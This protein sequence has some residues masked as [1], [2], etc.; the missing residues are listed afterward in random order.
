V[1]GDGRVDVAGVDPAGALWWGRNTSTGS[2]SALAAKAQLPPALAG[3]R[4]VL[5]ADL[6]GDGRKDVVGRAGDT[7]RTWRNTG[8]TTFAAATDLG[9]GWGALDR[10][11]AYDADGDDRTDV[12]G[13]DVAGTLWWGRNTGTGTTPAVAAKAQLGG[14]WGGVRDLQV[15]D[16]D[17]DRRADLVGRTGDT[18]KLWRGTGSA[19]Q[20]AVASPV[21]LSTGWGPIG[22]RFVQAGPVVHASHVDGVS[23]FYNYDSQGTR[24]W[25]FTNVATAATPNVTWYSGPNN[26]EWTRAKTVSG[27]FDGDGR[28]DALGLYNYDNSR[29]KLWGFFTITGGAVTGSLL[30]DSGAGNW[31]WN[32]TKLLAGDFNGDG[33]DDLAAL[34]RYD[35]FRTG[36]WLMENVASGNASWRMAWDSGAG[37]WDLNRTKAV[38]GDVNGDGK[39]DIAALYGY[40]GQRTAVW[41]MDAVTSGGAWRIAYDS[42][43]GIWDWNRTKV[44]AGDFTGD[45]RDD[46]D[47][48]YAYDGGRTR[49]FVMDGVAGAGSWRQVWD[50]GVNNWDGNRAVPVA[51]DFDGDGRDDVG[52]I[53]DYGNAQLKLWLNTDA[54]A[55]G[56]AR[57]VWDS[58]PGNWEARRADWIRS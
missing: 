56:A 2:T 54:G 41:V 3:V 47:A 28:P 4:D 15:L 57:I 33:K 42:G 26:W 6:D 29:S 34:Y 35:G 52:N 43:P 27:D 1:D 58:G 11:T 44:V 37:N 14:G 53:Y 55:S 10:L 7:L 21:T 13:T 31:D 48:Y 50:S 22:R 20:P 19:G 38:A 23:A 39:D 49:L 36:L 45:G 9:T 17:N 30:W 18:L 5:F 25:T 51:G 46:L 32:R 12:V 40:D 8:N 16:L 24:L